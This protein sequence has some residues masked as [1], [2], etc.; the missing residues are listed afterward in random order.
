[1][2]K[3]WS[4]A[5]TARKYFRAGI[6]F[7][8]QGERQRALE[9]FTKAIEL[10]PELLD[11]YLHRAI[12]SYEI[13]D[14]A[15]VISDLDSVIGHAPDTAAAY[16]WRSRTYLVMG[17]ADLALED[18][19]EAIELNPDEPA[20]PLFRSF[21]HLCQKEYE[22]AVEDATRA[23]QLGFEQEGYSNRALVFAKMENYQAAIE[24]WTRVIA[25]NPDHAI[26]YCERGILLE[27]IGQP[28]SALSDLKTGLK[29]K[30]QLGES[31]RVTS[32]TLLDKL[33]KP[34]R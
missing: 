17:R 12:V 32:E 29:N 33:Q 26:A 9:Q 15:G 4:K 13:G 24:D 21:I 11:A 6:D 28:E 22:A 25:L 1:M 2:F 10:D 16:Y 34:D 5:R 18:I 20:N 19:D 7:R 14:L 3:K 23:I 31:L 30:S 27:K 8:L